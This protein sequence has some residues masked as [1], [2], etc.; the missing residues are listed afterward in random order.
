MSLRDS[1]HRALESHDLSGEGI[2]SGSHT[3][4]FDHTRTWRV[5]QDERSAQCRDHLR[6]NTN[7]HALIYSNKANMKGWLWRSNDIRGT[8]GHKSSWHLSYRWGKT[9]INLTQ[10]ICSYRWW[11][12]DPPAPQRGTKIIIIIII[13]NNYY[14][15]INDNDNNNN[16]NYNS[17]NI[18]NNNDS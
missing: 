18:D 6:D 7:I 3:F 16:N 12:P 14:Y 2:V 13:N 17:S 5:S 9:T 15:D 8:S 4:F 10:E 1:H 11:K